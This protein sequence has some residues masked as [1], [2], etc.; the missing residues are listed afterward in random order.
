LFFR[1]VEKY[2]NDPNFIKQ[3]ETKFGIGYV[4][5]VL[6]DAVDLIKQ[7]FIGQPDVILNSST[8]VL[9]DTQGVVTTITTQN[10]STATQSSTITPNIPTATNKT[11][12]TTTKATT[13]PKK[14]TTTTK[15]T[16]TTTKKTTT[17]T[18]KKVTTTTAQPIVR[19]SF[20]YGGN[21]INT[22]MIFNEIA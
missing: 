17:T 9:L 2:K 6:G 22:S 4:M 16:T 19:C 7:M 10:N 15:K 18:V 8:T 5:K 14:V 3:M 12:A 21:S 1:D 13:T 11:T 20:V